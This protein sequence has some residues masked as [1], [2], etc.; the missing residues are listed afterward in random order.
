MITITKQ[1][2][3]QFILARQGLIGDYRFNGKDGAFGSRSSSFK[4]G[5]MKLADILK[6]LGIRK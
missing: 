4:I 2:A 6:A 3:G 5:T 1:Q